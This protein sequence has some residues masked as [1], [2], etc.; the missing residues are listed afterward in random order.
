MERSEKEGSIW[1]NR[2][3][4]KNLSFIVLR[5]STF[6]IACCAWVTQIC[7]PKRINHFILQLRHSFQVGFSSL[8]NPL[9]ESQSSPGVHSAV[10]F[11]K[12][13]GEHNL[14]EAEVGFCLHFFSKPNFGAIAN[15]TF[16]RLSRWS[17]IVNSF[18]SKK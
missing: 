15:S 12:D 16:V 4:H 3:S 13:I 10:T 1:L 14:T 6:W 18:P 2:L 7:C 17:A 9:F 11:L 5:I 8:Q